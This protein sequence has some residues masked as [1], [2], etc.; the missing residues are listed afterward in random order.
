M[1]LRHM[2]LPRFA[3]S[4]M[5]NTRG[6]GSVAYAT[7]A[8]RG[9]RAS[10]TTREPCAVGRISKEP[11]AHGRDCTHWRAR[12]VSDPM[13]SQE[14]KRLE[15]LAIHSAPSRS[16]LAENLRSLTVA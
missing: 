14:R 1:Q 6:A 15:F 16:R 4:I 13:A 8:N 10:R 7:V 9:H 2:R 12:S 5:L 3:R 11:H